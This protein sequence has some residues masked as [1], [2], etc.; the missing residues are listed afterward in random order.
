MEYLATRIS[1][2]IQNTCHHR[3]SRSLFFGSKF[4]SRSFRKKG[5]KIRSRS[6]FIVGSHIRSKIL[7]KILFA[8]LMCKKSYRLAGVIIFVKIYEFAITEPFYFEEKVFYSAKYFNSLGF[9]Y[10]CLS[11]LLIFSKQQKKRIRS[12]AK[13]H[14]IGSR[15]GFRSSLEKGSKIRSF[16]KKG[17]RKNA[18]R[19]GCVLAF[20]AKGQGI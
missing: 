1:L 18:C 14:Q 9:H 16:S 17:S 2:A 5:F 4:R 11:F 20:G 7:F 19:F 12:C 8:N 10:F 6:L 13:S 15:S 3:F